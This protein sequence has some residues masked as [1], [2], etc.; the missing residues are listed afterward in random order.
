MATQYN[1]PDQYRGDTFEGIEFTINKNGSPLDLTGAEIC[2]QVK[3]DKKT[4]LFVIEWTETDG[5]TITD[6]V[7]GVFQIDE[8]II[9]VPA[10]QYQQDVQITLASG[11]VFTPTFGTWL[12]I[13][14][15]TRKT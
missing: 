3:V 10:A 2:I 15:V 4:D 14:D 12:I 6:A 1:F 13:Q 8:T 11:E 7:N 5:I 9:D